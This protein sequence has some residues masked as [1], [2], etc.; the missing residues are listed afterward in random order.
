MGRYPSQHELIKQYTETWG[1]DK[2]FYFFRDF[3][4]HRRNVYVNLVFVLF[5]G[6]FGGQ[7]IY[8][9]DPYGYVY[10]I[11]AVIGIGGFYGLVFVI[12]VGLLIGSLPLAL[13]LPNI[14]RWVY[15]LFTFQATVA[16]HN[17]R[18]VKRLYEKYRAKRVLQPRA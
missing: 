14:V 1:S 5:L 18:L 4:R 16:G 3:N 13:L 15:D 17:N 7:R 9:G 2:K 6:L 11:L 10:I 8:M 12:N